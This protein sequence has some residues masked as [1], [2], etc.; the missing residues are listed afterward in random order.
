MLPSVFYELSIECNAVSAWLQ[1]LLAAISK[2]AR[3]TPLVLGRMLMDQSPNVSFLWLGVTVVGLQD[4]FLEEV[5][6]GHIPIDL[7]SAAWPGITQ[8]FLQLPTSSCS[9]GYVTRADECRLLFLSQSDRHTRL[10]LVQWKP[11]G[12]TPLEDADLEVRNHA[13]CEGHKLCYQG[14]EWDLHQGFEW[15]VHA[16]GLLSR[17]PALLRDSPSLLSWLLTKIQRAVR[18]IFSPWCRQAGRVCENVVSYEEMDCQRE[19]ISE[20]R[21]PKHPHL[22]AP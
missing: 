11:F 18:L 22:V 9:D 3:H 2:L 5:R 12:S 17:I 1:G 14:F 8:T 20:K 13:G 19:A 7:H 21:N 15:N 10:P 4:N 6:R 16:A